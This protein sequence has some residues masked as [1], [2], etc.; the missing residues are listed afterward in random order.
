MDVTF[1][2]IWTP[3]GTYDERKLYYSGKHKMYGLKSQCI[4]DRKGRVVH[5]IS[6]EKGATH[7]LTI[8][9]DNI[10][11]VK[12]VLRKDIYLSEDEDGSE[13]NEEM[14]WF[15]LVDAGYKGLQHLTNAI[16]PHK[17]KPNK[18]LTKQQQKF[19][20]DL[21]SERVICERYYGRLKTRYRIL[22]TKYR[23]SRD[24]YKMVFE[25]CVALTNYH[26]ILY[27]L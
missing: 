9:K 12:N 6:G 24:D 27:P 4:H 5:C 8:C 3:S 21:A 11:I 22:A 16:L 15:V 17:K 13:N 25:L 18:Q 26:I 20:K 10:N 23:N 7:D 14:Y 2:S 19:N 1:Q